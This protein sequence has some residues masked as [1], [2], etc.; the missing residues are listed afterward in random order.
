MVGQASRNLHLNICFNNK[1]RANNKQK[2][3]K[4]EPIIIILLHFIYPCICSIKNVIKI[5]LLARVSMEVEVKMLKI[6]PEGRRLIGVAVKNEKEL[7]LVA[8]KALEYIKS[9]KYE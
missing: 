9:F 3:T 8:R 6:V 4:L 2:T 7:G 1:I 5:L